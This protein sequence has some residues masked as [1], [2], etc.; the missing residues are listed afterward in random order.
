MMVVPFKAVKA[1]LS[2]RVRHIWLHC[3]SLRLAMCSIT[4]GGYEELWTGQAMK[5]FMC[6]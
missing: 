5:D 3:T 4:F 6:L 1:E 2:G